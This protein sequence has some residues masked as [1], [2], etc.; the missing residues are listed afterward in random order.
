M[1][2][3]KEIT[4]KLKLPM[5]YWERVM[6]ALRLGLSFESMCADLTMSGIQTSDTHSMRYTSSMA[7]VIDEIGKK[8]KLKR[9]D[10]DY[11]Y[12][13]KDATKVIADFVNKECDKYEKEYFKMEAKRHKEILKSLKALKKKLGRNPTEREEIKELE[14]MFNES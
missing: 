13:G 11:G 6:G 4:V 1:K 10:E 14:G 7:Y 2:K 3:E 9:D 8:T 12:A 5:F